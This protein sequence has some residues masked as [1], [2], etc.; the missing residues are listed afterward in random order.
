MLK[1]E[2]KIIKRTPPKGKN[3]Q[4]EKGYQP[5]RGKLDSSNSPKGGSGVPSSSSSDTKKNNKKD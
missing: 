5:I 4:F 3:H 1:K 2:N